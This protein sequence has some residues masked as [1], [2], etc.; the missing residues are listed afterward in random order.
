VRGDGFLDRLTFGLHLLAALWLFSLAFVIL[1]DVVGRGLFSSPLHGT[2]E[3]V[4]NS[5]VSIAFLQLTHAIRMRGMLRT[6][7]VEQFLP[8]A[9]VRVLRAIGYLVG[10]ALFGAMAWSSWEPM[11]S[12]WEIGEYSGE[13]ALRVPTYPVRTIIVA[14]SAL[15]SICYL[16]LAAGQFGARRTQRPH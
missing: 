12:A 14:M 11:L 15:A 3:I 10:A 16:M 5:I 8:E 13:G 2:P 4:S 1:V 6:D 9:G 7:I